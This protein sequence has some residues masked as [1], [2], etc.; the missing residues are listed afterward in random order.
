MTRAINAVLTGTI[1]RSDGQLRVT[2]Q[3]ADVPGGAVRWSQTTSV[4]LGDIFQLQDALTSRIVESL[5]VPLTPR[6]R[7][8]LSR[9]VPA[10]AKAY[11]F[12]LQK[13]PCVDLATEL[14]E[15]DGIGDQWFRGNELNAESFG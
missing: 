12:Y 15:I 2:A 10:N 8:A 14:L 5:A 1:L 9:D 6:D 13:N 7:Q 3:L 4:P 11:E